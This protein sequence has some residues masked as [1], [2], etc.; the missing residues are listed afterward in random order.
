[1]NDTKCS[2]LSDGADVIEPV[3][4]D[5]RKAVVDWLTENLHAHWHPRDLAVPPG[6]LAQDL[7]TVA[8]DFKLPMEVLCTWV[9]CQYMAQRTIHFQGFARFAAIAARVLATVP[10]AGREA[11]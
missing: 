4:L 1:M 7:Y 5:P 9:I 2:T 6:L 11:V 10:T 8:L 3:K